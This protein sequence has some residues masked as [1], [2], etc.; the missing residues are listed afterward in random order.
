LY[1]GTASA[2]VLIERH[3]DTVT[4]IDCL[5]DT[6]DGGHANRVLRSC[7]RLEILT[8]ASYEP[9]VWLGLSQ[10]HTLRGVNLEVVTFAAIAAALPRL[11]TLDVFGYV[12]A[13]PASVVGFFEDLLPRLR[14]FH[15]TGCWP[16]GEELTFQTTATASTSSL[17][18]LPALRELVLNLY[19]TVDFRIARKFMGA[20]P[21]LLR[22]PYAS[23]AN[24]DCLPVANS[25]SN[26]ETSAAA[27]FLSRVR[28]LELLGPIDDGPSG[29]AR[30]LRSAPQLRTFTA[31]RMEGDFLL[32]SSPPEGFA[33][34][35]IHPW[36]RSMDIEAWDS[37]PAD[38]IAQL[39]QLYF[40]RLRR[41]TFDKWSPDVY[42]AE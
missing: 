14:S 31:I 10:L 33:E 2:F 16:R 28:N 32:A 42:H 11:D 34:G 23:L 15:F 8:C 22:L 36:L 1:C 4:E 5:L 41:L 37:V 25:T 20:R 19:S 21:V 17:Q 9:N 18:E 29:L 27:A 24:A 12:S 26:A 35:F 6:A 3:S 13:S 38:G 30:V 39:R 40:P 7:K